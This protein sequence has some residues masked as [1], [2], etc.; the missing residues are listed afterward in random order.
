[1]RLIPQRKEVFDVTKLNFDK[2]SLMLNI[3]PAIRGNIYIKL[4]LLEFQ[5]IAHQRGSVLHNVP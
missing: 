2:L 4:F 1:M 3:K 5:M